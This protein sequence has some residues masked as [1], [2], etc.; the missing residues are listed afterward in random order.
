M[1]RR[2][3]LVSA[4]L[5]LLSTVPGCGSSRTEHQ[6]PP[7]A[8]AAPDPN[9]LPAGYWPLATSQPIIDKTQTLRLAPE[10]AHLSGG[11]RKALAKL[12]QVGLI[13]QGLYEQQR[14]LDAA[15]SRQKLAELPGQDR[16]AVRNLLSLYRLHQ[17]PIAVTLDNQR[18]AFLPVQPQP[19]GRNVYPWDATRAEI[20]AF[21]AAHPEQKEAILAPRTVVRRNAGGGFEAIPYSRAYAAE[22]GRAA[23]LLREAAG[24]VEPDDPAFAGYLRLRAD[25]LLSDDYEASDAAWIKGGFRHLNAQLG[26]YETYDDKLYG[27]K[28]FFSASLVSLRADETERLRPAIASLQKLEDSLP[29][30]PHRRVRPGLPIGVYDVIADFGQARGANTATILPNEQRIVAKHGRTILIRANILLDKDSFDQGT[31]VAWQAAVAPEHAGDLAS[32]GNFHRTVWHEVGHYLGVATSED[33]RDVD[34]ALLEEADAMEEMKADLV[35]LFL[36]EALA[37]AGVYDAATLRAVYAAGINRVVLAVRPLRDQPY[38]TMELVQ[39]NYFLEQGLLSFDPAS[40]KLAIHYD[41]YHQV[42]G[43]MLRAV[44]AIQRAGDKAAATAFIDRYS[45]WLPDL[46]ETIATAIRDAR[47]YRFRIFTYA[48]LGE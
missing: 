48:A 3:R 40:K 23:A 29:H 9:A 18:E 42:A 33:G 32:T 14:H 43:E 39:W 8:D 37:K 11:E 16:P 30:T 12:I 4:I 6:A 21:L 15:S 7:P 46:H 20:D 24:D 27:S 28:T 10:L 45:T 47:R 35:S 26:S 34:A 13:F 25:A 5:S 38:E 31:R 19:P 44:L 2:A 41:R 36:A 22:L 17:G 1:S